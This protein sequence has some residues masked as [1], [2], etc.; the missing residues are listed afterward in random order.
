MDKAD[1][2]ESYRSDDSIDKS[3]DRL[4]LK[5][6]SKASSHFLCYD[7][8]FDIEESEVPIFYL[9]KEFFYPFSIDNKEIGED[10]CDEE[11]CQYDSCIR[12]V[13]DCFL[14]YRFEIIRADH[15][16]DEA[17]ESQL[18]TRIFFDLGD[19]VFSL[20]SYIRSFL[21]KSLYL[22]SDLREDIHEYEDDDTDE[23][24]IETCDHDIG[25]RVFP[26][27]QMCRIY[28]PTHSPI[29][30]LRSRVGTEFEEYIREEE[31]HK[32][33]HEKITQN[34]SEKKKKAIGYD[35]LPEDFTKYD[36]KDSFES[37]HKRKL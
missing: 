14:S 35:F 28:F 37:E 34:I 9:S 3:D 11:F 13:S 30:D 12:D 5:Y 17:T 7:S 1:N 2:D 20:K 27:E 36:R 24:Y 25:S 4:G 26:S 15:F 29:M 32:K 10:E 6:Q 22:T 19:E 33:E 31:C 8:P 18:E 23:H 16:T 21:E